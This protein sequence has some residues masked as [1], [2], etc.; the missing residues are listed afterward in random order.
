MKS[1]TQIEQQLKKKTNPILVE[2]VILAKKNAAWLEVASL[3]TANRHDRRDAN[4]SDIAKLEGNIIAV[5]GKVLSQGDI[6]KKVKVVALGFSEKAKEK[7]LKAGC[8]A[9][10]LK[11]EIQ[12]NK[13][14]KGVVVFK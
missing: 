3:L 14:A 6:S 12:K 2:T 11:D 8:E 10:L 1:K 4:L 13:D 5:A 7:L 9:V